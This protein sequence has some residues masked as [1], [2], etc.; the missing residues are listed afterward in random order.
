MNLFLGWC[1]AGATILL[2]GLA[3]RLHWALAL[4]IASVGMFLFVKWRH[5]YFK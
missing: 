5:R 1:H 2:S 3:Y 4:L